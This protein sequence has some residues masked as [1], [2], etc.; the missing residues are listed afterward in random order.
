MK[1][2]KFQTGDVALIAVAHFIHDVYSSFL[3]PILPLLIEKLSLSFVGIGVLSIIQRVPSLLNPFVGMLADK[4]SVRYFLIIAP[5]LTTIGMSLLGLAPNAAVLGALLFLMGISSTLFHVPGPVFIRNVSGGKIGRGMSF[6]MLGGELA[7]TVGPMVILGGISLWGL[8]GTWRLVPF[9]LLVSLILFVRFR[10][11]PV[12]AASAP[13][14]PIAGISPPMLRFFLIL[15]AFTFFRSIMKS[16]FTTFLPTYMSERGASLWMSGIS[17][18]ILQLSGAVGTFAA[19]PISDKIGR[20]SSLLIIAFITPILMWLFVLSSGL[21]S[22]LL[23]VVMGLFLFANGPVLLALVQE[24]GTDR[25]AFFN[26]VYMTMSF[27]ISSLAALVIGLLADRFGLDVSFKTAAIL[28]LGG[29]PF[30]ML[31]PEKK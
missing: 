21:W 3:A 30:V 29:I 4:I 7:R 25:P 11:T 6:Y 22:F 14:K 18:S 10:R 19:G 23:L 2:I 20:R 27:F 12:N 31:L 9:G 26:G 1:K 8:E 13:G 24:I 5:A 16:A 28:A 17:L 15:L